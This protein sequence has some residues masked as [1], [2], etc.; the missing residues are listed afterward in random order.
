MAT[1]TLNLALDERLLK[2]VDALV[3]KE[4]AS[5]SEYFRRLALADLDRR[6]TI[7]SILDAANKKGKSLKFKDENDA[8]KAMSLK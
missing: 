8:M 3:K 4:M 7:T 1:K 5:R 2:R 6:E